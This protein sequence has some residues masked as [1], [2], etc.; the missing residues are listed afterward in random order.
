MAINEYEITSATS[1]NAFMTG[2]WL[3]Q[4]METFP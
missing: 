2:T 1:A 3:L 4:T